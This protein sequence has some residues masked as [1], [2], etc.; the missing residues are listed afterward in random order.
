MAQIK[1]LLNSL[2]TSGPCTLSPSIES[3]F[4]VLIK[5]SAIYSN[6]TICKQQKK[7]NNGLIF[8]GEL[9]G[10]HAP[11]LSSCP[12]GEVSGCL[13]SPLRQKASASSGKMLLL[14][15]SLQAV[16]VCLSGGHTGLGFRA[17]IGANMGVLFPHQWVTC[18]VGAGPWQPQLRA[19]E[20]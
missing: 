8:K 20:L 6:V 2:K 9:G 17:F 15:K 12:T 3:G 13:L 10:Q 16:H 4:G 5:I 18:S 1:L 7:Y 14:D 19:L 11:T